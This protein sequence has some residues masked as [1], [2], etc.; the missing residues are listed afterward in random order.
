MGTLNKPLLTQVFTSKLIICVKQTHIINTNITQTAVSIYNLKKTDKNLAIPE[1]AK[2]S[3][4][5]LK[6]LQGDKCH[7][8]WLPG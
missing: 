5:Y 8:R 4:T 2:T 3:R 1:R 6:E 7:L